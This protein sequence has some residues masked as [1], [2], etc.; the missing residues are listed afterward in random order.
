VLT[1]ECLELAEEEARRGHHVTTRVYP[2]VG[3]LFDWRESAATRD[4]RERVRAF[5]AG[6]LKG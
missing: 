3:H 6:H 1:S 4:A 2:E 5:L